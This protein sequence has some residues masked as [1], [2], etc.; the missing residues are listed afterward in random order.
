M[1]WLRDL[2]AGVSILTGLTGLALAT[3]GELQ[4]FTV[5]I[6]HAVVLGVVSLGFATTD[7]PDV[8]VSTVLSITP[9]LSPVALVLPGEIGLIVVSVLLTVGGL[10]LSLQR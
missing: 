3:T 2:L 9:L 10:A 5:F 4:F 8:S 6:G 7:S 1:N